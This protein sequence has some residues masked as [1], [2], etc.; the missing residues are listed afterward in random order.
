MMS[1]LLALAGATLAAASLLSH[2]ETQKDEVAQNS[3]ARQATPDSSP[4]LQ[5]LVAAMQSV[6]WDKVTTAEARDTL[7]NSLARTGWSLLSFDLH[8]Y[9][10][11]RLASDA[12]GRFETGAS[13]VRRGDVVSGLGRPTSLALA[14]P[15]SSISVS[16]PDDVDRMLA[17]GTVEAMEYRISTKYASSFRF[18]PDTGCLWY[19]RIVSLS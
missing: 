19:F 4:G 16:A 1:T 10:T 9:Q 12:S 3:V 18:N 2:A 17:A 5:N 6:D 13:C 15:L 11:N 7:A 8:R 14:P